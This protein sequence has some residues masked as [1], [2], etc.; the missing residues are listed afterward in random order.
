MLPYLKIWQFG[1]VNKILITKNSLNIAFDLFIKRIR[2]I[3]KSNPF[4]AICK[5]FKIFN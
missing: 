3:G 1:Q 2:S 4:K 5:S